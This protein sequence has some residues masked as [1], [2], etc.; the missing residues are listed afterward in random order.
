[1]KVSL[2]LLLLPLLLTGGPLADQIHPGVAGEELINRLR[3]DY[4]RTR[5]LSYT[6]ARQEM[7]TSIDNRDG[8]VILVYTGKE[9]ETDG[10]PDHTVVNTEH[11]WPQSK[12]KNARGEEQMK[13]DLHHL[14]ATASLVNNKR[15]SRPFDD[16]PDTETQEWWASATALSEIPGE[17]IEG[18]SESTDL[19]FEPREAHKGNVA[20]AMFYFYS[21]YGDRQIDRDW[22]TPQIETLISW[23]ELDPVDDPERVRSA[24]IAAVQGNENP[25]VLDPTL[26]GRALSTVGGGT[27]IT[28]ADADD[29]RDEKSA[30]VEPNEPDYQDV[31]GKFFSGATVV[32]ALLCGF[33]FAA[34]LQLMG[35]GREDR[36]VRLTAL[37]LYAATFLFLFSVIGFNNALRCGRFL[38]QWI[39]H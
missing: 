20:R 22:F 9:F 33:S 29:L 16:I 30:A 4:Q 5:D 38:D 27:E 15:G 35:S 23:H 14:F 11:T 2:P 7:F 3:Q 8:K 25:F 32:S 13:A 10:I 31:V 21:I 19:V 37:V 39:T 18:Y 6:D 17:N 1:M 28:I 34:A 36:G 26:V 12:F 24:R